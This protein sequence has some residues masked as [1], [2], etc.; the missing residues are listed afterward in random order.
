MKQNKLLLAGYYWD[1]ATSWV[2]YKT[3]TG[4]MVWKKKK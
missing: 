4:D 1:G 3:A 2:L